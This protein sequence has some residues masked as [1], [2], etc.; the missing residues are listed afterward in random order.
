MP[1]YFNILL[2][3]PYDAFT[4]LGCIKL[5]SP[6]ATPDTPPTPALPSRAQPFILSA[7]DGRSYGFASFGT[8]MTNM[9]RH[10]ANIASNPSL[11]PRTFCQASQVPSPGLDE[12]QINSCQPPDVRAY[13]VNTQVDAKARLLVARGVHP[14]KNSNLHDYHCQEYTLGL[15]PPTQSTLLQVICERARTLHPEDPF[16]GIPEESFPLPVVPISPSDSLHRAAFIG[17]TNV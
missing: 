7:L 13:S 4:Q 16:T 9:S 10:S 17:F 14:Y 1:R 3:K 6:T 8:P 2:L 15:H 11:Y 5:I 12:V